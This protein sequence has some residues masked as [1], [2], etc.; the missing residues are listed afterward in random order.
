MELLEINGAEM[1]NMY[2]YKIIFVEN[3][4]TKN[5]TTVIVTHRMGSA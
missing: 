2:R 3:Q 1:K 4:E 5:K